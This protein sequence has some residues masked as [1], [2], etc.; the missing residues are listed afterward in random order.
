[1]NDRDKNDPDLLRQT[2]EVAHRGADS[3]GA[4]LA[5]DRSLQHNRRSAVT[6]VTS[7]ATLVRYEETINGR[8]YV[9]EVSA[10]S[11]HRWRAQIKRLP[12]GRAAL[13][14]FYGTTAQEAAT[15]LRG[16][17]SRASRAQ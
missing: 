8:D 7:T 1:V 11:Q 5:H 13:M 16:W 10:V 6:P 14:P 9:I 12:G 17:L 2:A 4:S 15:Q 3:Y